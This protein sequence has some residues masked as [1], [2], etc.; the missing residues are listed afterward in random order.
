MKLAPGSGNL[1]AERGI[2]AAVV[3]I[4]LL[5]ANGSYGARRAVPAA[6]AERRLW[7]SKA[8]FCR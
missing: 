3:L 6:K 8:A 5:V 2:H 7:I 1:S 4:T